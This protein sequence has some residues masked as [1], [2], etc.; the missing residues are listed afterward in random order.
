MTAADREKEVEIIN[1]VFRNL[2]KKAEKTDL[3]GIPFYA[4]FIHTNKGPILLENNSRPNY[5]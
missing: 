4:A 2:K 1:K 5:C 3:R